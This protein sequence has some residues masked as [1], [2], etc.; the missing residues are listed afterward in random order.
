MRY[1]LMNEDYEVI[2]FSIDESFR[3]L[4][5]IN[6]LD[7]FDH[8]PIHFREA[9][10]RYN[11]YR[12]LQDRCL[13]PGRRDTQEIIKAL[14][15]HNELELSFMSSGLSLSDCYW[16]RPSGSTLKW[17]DVNCF[18]RE[19]D[20]T[21]SEAILKCDYDTVTKADLLTPDLTLDGISKKAWIRVDGKP[22]LLK[23]EAGQS[24]FVEQSELLSAR[25]TERLLDPVDIIDYSH[26][27]FAGE[28]YIACRS[29][30]KDGEEFV[31]AS[32]VLEMM[33]E[34]NINSLKMIS[35]DKAFLKKFTE[36]IEGLGVK[37][38]T[39]YFAKIAAVFNLTLAGDCHSTN[40]G[41]IR[42]LKTLKLRPAPLFD[43]G[44]SFGCFGQP[45]E[46]GQLS[47][48]SV[49]IK[50]PQ[51]VFLIVLFNSNVLNTSWDYSWYD[52]ARLEG[53]H[54]DIEKMLKGF[55]ESPDKYIELLKLAF[56]YQLD[57]LNKSSGR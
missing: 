36:T 24:A 55:P 32:Q 41:F 42:D 57:Y 18:V 37:N 34:T 53:F 10:I 29:M 50:D 4:S 33:N 49:A 20:T 23:S 7:G 30:I 56:D 51:S 19:Y 54:E 5:D 1:T 39:A 31:P 27:E 22:L 17:K 2:D 45:M 28:N 43:R 14:K 52:P 3:V 44:R 48:A 9:T 12:L 46:N 38:V 13:H 8:A 40:F 26:Y 47:A 11:L 6:L 25:L 35:K 21:L 15:A 16:Y